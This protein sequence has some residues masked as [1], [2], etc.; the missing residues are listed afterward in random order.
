MNTNLFDIF[1]NVNQANLDANKEEEKQE[2]QKQNN[3]IRNNRK[4]YVRME[5][6]PEQLIEW[7]NVAIGANWAQDEELVDYIFDMGEEWDLA[8]ITVFANRNKK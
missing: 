3:R 8:K 4:T 1:D 2:Q 7:V 6:S 5:Y